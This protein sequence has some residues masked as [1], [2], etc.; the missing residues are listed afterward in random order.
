MNTKLLFYLGKVLNH[1]AKNLY[2]L[3]KF[4]VQAQQF[5]I[6]PELKKVQYFKITAGKLLGNTLGTPLRQDLLGY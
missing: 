1:V 4:R 6:L 2:S 5:C 3:V